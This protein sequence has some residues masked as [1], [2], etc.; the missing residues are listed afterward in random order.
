MMKK[1]RGWG[2]ECWKETPHEGIDD[3]ISSLNQTIRR[4][5]LVTSID[6]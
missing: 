3:A 4:E 2:Q 5:D 1:D 6:L